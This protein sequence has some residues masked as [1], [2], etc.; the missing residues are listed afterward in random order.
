MTSNIIQIL[1]NIICIFFAQHI[2]SKWVTYCGNNYSEDG[3]TIFDSFFFLLILRIVLILNFI[4][5]IMKLVNLLIELNPIY[6]IGLILVN[7]VLGYYLANKLKNYYL[8]YYSK[9]NTNIDFLAWISYW[10]DL[11]ITIVFPIVILVIYLFI[12]IMRLLTSPFNKFY[13]NYKSNNE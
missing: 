8:K 9:I 4:F 7:F 5:P 1:V 11:I 3:I 13:D 10:C 12:N 2:I 6:S